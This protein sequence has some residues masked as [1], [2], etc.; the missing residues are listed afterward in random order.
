MAAGPLVVTVPLIVAVVWAWAAR[1]PM[2]K[3]AMVASV[4]IRSRARVIGSPRPDLTSGIGDREIPAA[5]AL[6]PALAI[7]HDPR[8]RVYAV[9][10]LPRVDLEES[11]RAVAVAGVGIPGEQ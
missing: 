2:H 10:V 6:R 4:A 3:D 5:D 1:P 8:N 9:R 7:D 11:D